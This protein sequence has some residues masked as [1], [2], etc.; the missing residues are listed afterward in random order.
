MWQLATLFRSSST[1]PRPRPRPRPRSKPT[2]TNDFPGS[3][4]EPEIKTKTTTPRTLI[5]YDPDHDTA[6]RFWIAKIYA[7][8]LAI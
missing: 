4:Q 3:T 2:K 7:T 5:D 8:K 1:R 6:I